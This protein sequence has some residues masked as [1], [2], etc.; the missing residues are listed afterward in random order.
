MRQFLMGFAALSIASFANAATLTWDNGGGGTDFSVAD[1]WDTN[2]APVSGVDSLQFNTTVGE[3]GQL[4][5]AF[6]VGNGEFFNAGAGSVVRIAGSGHLTIAT[7]GSLDFSGAVLAESGNSAQQVTLQ[8]GAT[9][10]A[11]QFFNEG[12]WT[13]N[14]SSDSSGVTTFDVNFLFL[15]G[16]TLNVNLQGYDDSNGPL[17]LFDY[18]TLAGAGLFAGT[19]E[20]VNVLG[21]TGTID[22]SYDQGGGDLTIALTNV[23]VATPEPST[24]GLMAIGAALLYNVRKRKPKLV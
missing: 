8:A 21:G 11:N 6:T 9:A 13:H 17:I 16:G 20:T 14:F 5:T 1:N 3:V 12:N 7:G 15:R 2:T 22:Y 24:L 19:F 4:S 10:T 23:M 18:N